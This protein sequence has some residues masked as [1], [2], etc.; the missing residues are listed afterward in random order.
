MKNSNKF[1]PFL[2]STVVVEKG[3][4][5]YSKIREGKKWR[6]EAVKSTLY[7]IASLS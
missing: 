1:L 4:I 3:M 5:M 2:H 7:S 6:D